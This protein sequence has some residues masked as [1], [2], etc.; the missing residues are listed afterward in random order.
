MSTWWGERCVLQ[1][2]SLFDFR[3]PCVPP[4]PQINV[5]AARG[6]GDGETV[7]AP[8]SGLSLKKNLLL[9]SYSP[10]KLIQVATVVRSAKK[11]SLQ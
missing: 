11:R 1:P 7:P 2:S 6:N 10:K 4:T 5:V 9:S 3:W 8:P